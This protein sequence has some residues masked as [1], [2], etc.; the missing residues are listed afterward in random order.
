[1]RVVRIFTR[2]SGE[3]AIEIREVPMTGAERPVSAT[4]GCDSIFFRETPEGH[5]QDFHNAPRRQL[6]FLTSGIRE[7]TGKT[8]VV[9]NRTGAGGRIA[10]EAAAKSAPDG[11]TAALID[12]TYPM[13]AG[14]YDKLPWDVAADL[15]P[16]A[17]IAQT[18]FVVVVNAGS[19]LDSL[20]ALIAEARA[21]PGKLTF[22]SA[23]VGSVIHVVSELFNANARVNLTHIPY[24]GMS[25][26][27]VALQAG[28]I[29][30][31]IAASPTAL[32]PI[33]GGKAR[34][35]AVSTAQRSAA[36]PGVPT[37]LEQGV[38]YVVTNW[39]GF[40]FP[41]G[42]SPDA[43]NALRADVGRALAAPD[44]KEKLTATGAGPSNFTPE[45]FAQ[46]LKEDTRRW[47]GVIKASGIRV[48]Q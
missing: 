17:M 43:I 9:E 21:R 18:P 5:V 1:M 4:F 10:W 22:G 2:D 25:D 37:A 32:G 23:G 24:K 42:P 46:F 35:L 6:I 45:E 8:F 12:A 14:L 44:V 41:R 39:F 20:A 34:G 36:F 27:S 30:L 31:I 13:L 26:A 40:A 48:E 19:K 38:D 47:T 29:D 16:S 7:Q 28:Q 3:S 11:T 15:V 33:R